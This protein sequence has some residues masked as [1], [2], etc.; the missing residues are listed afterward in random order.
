MA[1][2]TINRREFV[3]GCSVMTGMLLSGCSS[4]ED[5]GM[6]GNRRLHLSMN[7]YSGS[8]YYRR[9][10]R[11]FMRDLDQGLAQLS[12]CTLDGLEP[13]L[14]QAADVDRLMPLI[15]K[16]GMEIRSFYVNSVLHQAEEAD[17]SIAHIVTIA[18]KAKQMGVRIVVTNPSP[19]GWGSKEDKNDAQLAVQAQS[20]NKLGKAL[21][22]LGL[23]LA[24]HNHDSEFRQAAREFHHMMVGTDPSLVT[25]C[26][27]AHWIYRGSGNSSVA[28]FD[29]L[30][31]YGSRVTELH[32]RQSRNNVWSEVFDTGDI[33]YGRLA[34]YLKA[35]GMRPHVVLEQAVETGTPHTMGIGTAFQLSAQYARRVFG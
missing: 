10:G 14:G 34:A 30:N 21:K 9:E 25:L 12:V 3:R 17:K 23:T 20:L 6:G 22:S 32:L 24:Y 35:K 29:I 7:Q 4:L 27:D 19:I 11:D 28:L 15:S 13:T 16:H 2:N 8:V 5:V 18:Q 31:L 26:L 1:V 33:D